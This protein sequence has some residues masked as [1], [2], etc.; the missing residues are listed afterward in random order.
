MN[1]EQEEQPKY[2]DSTRKKFDEEVDG[3]A[4]EKIEQEDNVLSTV[5]R[6]IPHAVKIPVLLAL[7]AI[8]VCGVYYIGLSVLYMILFFDSASWST[9][10]LFWATLWITTLCTTT[11]GSLIMPGPN[12]SNTGSC[13]KLIMGVIVYLNMMGF[14]WC[15]L[16][17]WKLLFYWCNYWNDFLMSLEGSI[18]MLPVAAL[19]LFPV[20]FLV[21]GGALAIHFGTL[22]L[23]MEC[24]LLPFMEKETG[25][26][27]R[28]YLSNC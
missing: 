19:L 21:I 20:F 9:R 22:T 13:S 3:A 14:F 4:S 18:L 28:A 6:R 7:F 5:V 15:G 11:C 1:Q 23:V 10:I 12:P 16:V 17:G 8:M 27:F 2:H 26:R 25:R 24:W